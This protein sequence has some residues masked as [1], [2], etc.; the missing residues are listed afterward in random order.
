MT[1]YVRRGRGTSF[2][3]FR[4]AI[5][6]R[7][8]ATVAEHADLVAVGATGSRFGVGWYSAPPR[9]SGRV[10]R[11]GNEARPAPAQ[12]LDDPSSRRVVVADARQ[13]VVDLVHACA[14]AVDALQVR[15][16]DHVTQLRHRQLEDVRLLQVT[17]VLRRL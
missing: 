6:R 14:V 2:A 15:V 10:L 16:G 8:G 4:S 7:V 11:G 3:R 13:E 1:I 17:A 5:C 9:E 12:V